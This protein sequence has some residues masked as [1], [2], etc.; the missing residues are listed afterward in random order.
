MERALLLQHFDTLAETPDAVEKLRQLI[1]NLA[2][3][4]ILFGDEDEKSNWPRKLLGEIASQITKGA[5]PTSYDFQYQASGIRFVKVENV[6]DGRIQ[7]DGIYQFIS[8]EAH[9]FLKRSQLEAGDV[10]F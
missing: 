10:L 6:A 1:L 5:T 4:G 9:E 7:H 2:A 8:P 3:H